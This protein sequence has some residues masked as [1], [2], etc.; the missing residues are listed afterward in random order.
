MPNPVRSL[1]SSGVPGLDTVLA[2]GFPR[3]RLYLIEGDPGAGKTTAALQFLLDGVRSEERC[4]YVT[5][6][7]T[8]DELEAVAES[9]GWSLEHLDIFELSAV[10]QQLELDNENTFFHSADVELGKTT[11]IL[12]GAVERVNPTRVVFDSLSEMRLLA[13]SPLRYR[14]QILSLKQYF[15]GKNSTVLFLDDRSSNVNDLQVRSL[16]HGVIV[17]ER[18]LPEYGVSRRNLSVEKL[19]GVKFREGNHHFIIETGGLRVFPRL[20]AS[21]AHRPF[22][23]ES[24]PSGIQGLDALL[25]GGVDR[26]TS[27]VLLG[28]PGT[29]K[30]TLALR[31]AWLA[32]NRGEQ[33][34]FFTFDETLGTLI[35]RAESLGMQLGSLMTGGLLRI[36]QV[37]PA[38]ISPGE[39]TDRI[40]QGVEQRNTRMV[41][42]DSI[43][44]YH[45]AMPG[46]GFLNLQLHELL[47]YLNQLGIVTLLVLVQQGFV[48]NMRTAVDLT[49]LADTVVL[50]RYFEM[51]GEVRQAIS[52]IKKRSGNHERTLREF[53]ITLTGIV[54]GEPLR[55]FEG[56]L[57]GLPRHSVAKE[58]HRV[59]TSEHLQTRMISAV[60]RSEEERVL[61]LSMT[62]RDAELTIG[63]LVKA[64]IFALRC[65]DISDLVSKFKEG[66]AALIVAED[67]LGSGSARVLAEA[68]SQQ[69]SWSELPILLIT[70]GGDTSIRTLNTFSTLSSSGNVTLLER[71][72]R[73]LTLVNS[74]Q[75]ALRSRR[76]QY[77]VRDLLDEREAVLRSI[78]DAF[79]TLNPQWCY[80]YANE[81]AAAL[82]GKRPEELVGANFWKVFPQYVGT[83]YHE[84]L[85]RAFEKQEI[86]RF[87]LFQK[88]AQRWLEIRV[89]PSPKGLS[90]LTID[91]TDQKHA[92]ERLESTVA[93]RTLKLRETIGE[94]EAFSY[95]ISHDL[96][97]P[98]RAMQAYSEVLAEDYGS[99][100]PPEGQC[101]LQ[102]I[103]GAAIRLD[104][105]IGDVLTY[106]RVLR[107]P[108]EMETI[109]LEELFTTI[110]DGYP[111]FQPYKQN[112]EL[113]RPLLPVKGNE[114][115]L[116]QCATNLIGNAL[117]F[118]SR[119]KTPHIK[120]WT[121]ADGE[122]VA[123]SISD[124]GI[125]VAPKDQARIFGMF[126]RVHPET[127]YEGTGIGLAI[128]RKAVDRMNGTLSLE[129]TEGEGS[130][131]RIVLPR[132]Q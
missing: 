57:S 102:R 29:G 21:E 88:L 77:Q 53:K 6:S 8:R 26:G 37:D 32:A 48:G 84:E 69:P 117:K 123:L 98:L 97:S 108:I 49:Y 109:D 83:R 51:S 79:I 36:T 30:S 76:R 94:L 23:R 34:E 116:T 14:R 52:V 9:H 93:E 106:S 22:T 90:I 70:S 114:S 87:E 82:A 91:I 73:P 130:T 127:N 89:Y 113:V 115:S 107:A 18:A 105:L 11:Q 27:T 125:G 39:L 24:F 118:V 12:L 4:L 20:V 44:G 16:A 81:K 61:V 54:V 45:Y 55:E 101:Y 60:S 120:I 7:E 72:F 104:K 15:S 95:S 31:H 28:P 92:E 59:R 74:L 132:G 67:A 33:V 86:V 96:R 99:L 122:R 56:I 65:V 71:P 126:Q 47:A 100:L 110:I 41:I 10:E 121:E 1:C 17:L 111:S 38:E 129:S 46:E 131:F 25:G 103:A 35:A 119:D 80:T 68:L 85:R 3:N 64:E 62:E 128:V 63:F 50:F 66:C 2:G 124:N 42:I 75:S 43:N 78:N 5:L 58:A 112:I 40:R 13:E 19:R